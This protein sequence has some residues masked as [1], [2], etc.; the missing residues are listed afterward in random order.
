MFQWTPQSNVADVLSLGPRTAGKLQRVGVRSVEHLWAAQP[1]EIARRLADHRISAQII[2]DWQR[3]A[4]LILAAPQ[5][6]SAAVRILAA[7]GYGSL[8]KIAR[9]TP[10]ELLSAIESQG[11]EKNF[12]LP[13]ISD[14]SDW[15]Q[16]ARMALTNLAA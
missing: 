16:C 5:L 12:S 4:Q 3:E 14:L 13:S 9:S 10:T 11:K 6:S 8:E 2:S 7:A 15:I 1:H